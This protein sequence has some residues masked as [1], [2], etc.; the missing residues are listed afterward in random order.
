MNPNFMEHSHDECSAV[1]AVN[2]FPV[3]WNPSVYYLDHNGGLFDT[4]LG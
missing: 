1:Q 4:I 3:L 2:K